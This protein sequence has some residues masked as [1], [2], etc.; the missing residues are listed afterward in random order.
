MPSSRNVA[1]LF[2]VSLHTAAQSEILIMELKDV[3]T[4]EPYHR[5]Y[6][7]SKPTKLGYDYHDDERHE[8]LKCLNTITVTNFESSGK[9][10]VS[11][12]HERKCAPLEYEIFILR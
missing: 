11:T 2:L 3:L 7:V 8:I 9:K 4:P 10:L 12:E 6:P 5:Y 1:V